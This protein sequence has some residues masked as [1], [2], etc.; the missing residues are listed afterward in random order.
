MH[1]GS[2]LMPGAIAFDA[3]KTSRKYA[4]KI[5]CPDDNENWIIFD[6]LRNKSVKELL[7]IQLPVPEYLTLF[8][9]T[10]DG[11]VIPANPIVMMS[12]TSTSTLFK[13]YDLLIGISDS[14]YKYN[15]SESESPLFTFSK[16]RQEKIVRTLVRNIFDYH[17]QVSFFVIIIIILFSSSSSSFFN[18]YYYRKNT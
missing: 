1:S 4:Q 17:L 5:G 6:C 12:E 11:I 13:S 18:N 10:V 2:A 14:V 9:P 16:K 3:I 8:G 15:L 7:S